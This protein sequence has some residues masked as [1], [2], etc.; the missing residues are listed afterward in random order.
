MCSLLLYDVYAHLAA[1]CSLVNMIAVVKEGRIHESWVKFGGAQ[2][3]SV[4]CRIRMC[5]QVNVLY[6]KIKTLCFQNYQEFWCVLYIL[7]SICIKIYFYNKIILLLKY[8]LLYT[9][10]ILYRFNIKLFIF[11]FLLKL[12]I[13]LYEY[14]EYFIVLFRIKVISNL[15]I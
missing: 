13:L 10:N 8:N 14:F 7:Y 9:L 4:E 15:I 6:R 3:G 5:H 12:K 2:S 1:R 11:F